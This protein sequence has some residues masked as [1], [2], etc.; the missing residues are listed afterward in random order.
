MNENTSPLLTWFSPTALL[1][2]IQALQSRWL[3][4]LIYTYAKQQAPWHIKHRAEPSE[5]RKKLVILDSK[6]TGSSLAKK[7]GAA[8]SFCTHLRLWFSIL[9]KKKKWEREKFML[10]CCALRC[11]KGLTVWWYECAIEVIKV[12]IQCHCIVLL[13]SHNDTRVQ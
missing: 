2:L 5:G 3:G 1:P 6:A 9:V 10:C 8:I 13:Y 11:L 12:S 7:I 4:G